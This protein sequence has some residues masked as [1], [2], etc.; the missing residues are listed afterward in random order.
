MSQPTI[1]IV[2]SN[3]GNVRRLGEAISKVLLGNIVHW[4]DGE[5]GVMWVGANDCDLCILSYELQNR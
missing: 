2:D 3:S 5:S 1:L 4:E